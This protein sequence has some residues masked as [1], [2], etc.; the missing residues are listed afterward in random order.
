LQVDRG[1]ELVRRRG[2][3]RNGCRGKVLGEKWQKIAWRETRNHWGTSLR[4]V[5]VLRH[6]VLQVVYGGHSS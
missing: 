5:R 6:R 3:E 2:K 1:K 4:L